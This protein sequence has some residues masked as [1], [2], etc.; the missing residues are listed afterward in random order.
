MKNAS[1]LKKRFSV[2][3]FCRICL[4]DKKNRSVDSKIPTSVMISAVSLMVVGIV[5]VVVVC[6]VE[7]FVMVPTRIEP[8]VSRRIG[9]VGAFVS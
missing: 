1:W 3:G 5:Y 9:F 8:I 2:F 4:V 6:R 7:S